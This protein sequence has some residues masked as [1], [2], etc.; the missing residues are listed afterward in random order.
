MTKVSKENGNKRE[1][2]CVSRSKGF[3]CSGRRRRIGRR[4]GTYDYIILAEIELDV[5]VWQEERLR[6]L[7]QWF[8]LSRR[9][10]R[11]GFGCLALRN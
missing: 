8:D 6:F 5:E 3:R 1:Q 9:R 7:E 4:S 11:K 2:I 10:I